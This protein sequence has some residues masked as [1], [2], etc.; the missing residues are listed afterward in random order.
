MPDQPETEQSFEEALSL[1]E[2]IVENLERGEPELSG[3]G[4][5]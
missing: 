2:R 5:V 1:L 4:Q 3:A